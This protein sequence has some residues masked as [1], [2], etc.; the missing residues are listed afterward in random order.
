[1]GEDYGGEVGGSQ[2]GDDGDAGDDSVV[3]AGMFYH[4]L[5]IFFSLV[6]R[7]VRLMCDCCKE[8]TRSWLEAVAQTIKA[9]ALLNM[10]F[11][12]DINS[13]GGFL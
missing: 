13:D 3:E 7:A 1:M 12:G 11:Y 10:V 2:E 8:R 9:L 4:S 6:K 5:F